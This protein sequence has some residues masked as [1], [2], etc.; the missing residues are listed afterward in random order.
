MRTG[1]FV[2]V[3]FPLGMN[4]AELFKSSGANAH[5]RRMYPDRD[6]NYISTTLRKFVFAVKKGD[7]VV[8]ADGTRVLGLG[9][10][11]GDYEYVDRSDGAPP[12]RRKVK[13]L[14]LSEWEAPVWNGRKFP[15]G[16]QRT[17]Y[18]LNEPATLRAVNQRLAR[19]AATSERTWH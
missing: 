9:E 6:T 8:A 13:W 19:T 11:V 16:Y 4:L 1:S 18:Q 7:V 14:D 3:G 12:D 10:V 5:I 15:E 2:A 17:L